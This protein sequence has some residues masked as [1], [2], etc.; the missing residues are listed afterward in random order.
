MAL[1]RD[2]SVSNGIS[3]P[4]SHRPPRASRR[5]EET[6][7]DRCNHDHLGG[8]QA[9]PLLGEVGDREERGREGL[10]SIPGVLHPLPRRAWKTANRAERDDRQGTCAELAAAARKRGARAAAG[11][12]PSAPHRS[13]KP[14]E[15]GHPRTDRLVRRDTAR[16]PP[17][18]HEVVS[19]SACS[20]PQVEAH[21]MR[22]PGAAR[23]AA[24]PSARL[25]SSKQAV[26]VACSFEARRAYGAHHPG[27]PHR[28]K[29]VLHVDRWQAW[30]P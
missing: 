23:R 21:R 22:C 13:R 16:Q 1:W 30:R 17:R 27:L 3:V 7:K 26:P 8:S 20:A 25:P 11:S 15:Q 4:Q 19:A 14:S 6:R 10:L 2:R 24:R 28:G 18:Q 29:G 12:I 5:D 9:A